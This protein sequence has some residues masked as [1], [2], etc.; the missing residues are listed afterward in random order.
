MRSMLK[1][2]EFGLRAG[3]LVDPE[4]LPAETR[5]E[6][7]D[8]AKMRGKAST[9]QASALVESACTWAHILSEEGPSATGDAMQA[10]L[11]RIADKAHELLHAMSALHP[12]AISAFEAHWDYLM[13]GSDSPRAQSDL[14]ASMRG[15][16]GKF[17]GALWTLTHDLR[18]AA[19]YASEMVILDRSLKPRQQLARG[20]VHQIACAH[21]AVF[22]TLPKAYKG[23]WFPEFCAIA[24]A[25]KPLELKIGRALVEGVVLNLKKPPG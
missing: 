7:H 8:L 11:V 4:F 1:M 10:S 15:E 9:E 5:Q 20:L 21:E 22:G 3:M 25:A 16:E 6:L 13:L 23:N 19:D 14:S 24:G 18:D 2:P 17:L 12:S